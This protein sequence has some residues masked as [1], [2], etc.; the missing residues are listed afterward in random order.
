VGIHEAEG[1]APHGKLT[2]A[3]VGAVHEFGSPSRGI[4]ERSFIRAWF[5]GARE[6]IKLQMENVAR[7]VTKGKITRE[8]ALNQLG[9][10]FVGQIQQRIARRIPPPL[11]EKTIMRKGSDVPLIDTGQLR[12]SITY[13]VGSKGGAK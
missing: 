10:F 9:S 1:N 11:N 7:G 3:E 12:S 6:Q 13:S 4:P 5:D 8:Q 2:N